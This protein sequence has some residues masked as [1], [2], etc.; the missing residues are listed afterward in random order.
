MATNNGSGLQSFS[1]MG[2]ILGSAQC[3]LFRD[4]AVGSNSAVSA[5]AQAIT[6]CLG[7]EPSNLIERGLFQNVL[8]F[9]FGL[10]SATQTF[11]LRVIRWYHRKGDTSS[12]FIPV[13][14]FEGVCT[15]G[16]PVGI[17][18]NEFLLNT[19]GLCYNIAPDT[20]LTEGT[21]AVYTRSP[22]TTGHVAYILVDLLGAQYFSF[23]YGGSGTVT[24]ANVLYG[25]V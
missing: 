10:G 20:T 8:V 19:E 21:P 25:Q 3:R 11:S 6:A 18:S 24:S 14:A 13:I 12:I 22:G 5:Y 2:S 4:R 1:G 9:P 17:A 7:T 23:D 16:A 15:M